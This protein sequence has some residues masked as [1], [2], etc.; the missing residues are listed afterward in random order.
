[1]KDHDRSLMTSG[2]RLYDLCLID[3]DLFLIHFCNAMT[4]DLSLFPATLPHRVRQ[5][6]Q[7]RVGLEFFFALLETRAALVNSQRDSMP[8]AFSLFS[9]AASRMN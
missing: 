9:S 5:Q 4:V 6:S 7:S 8:V 2:R 3:F 1:M